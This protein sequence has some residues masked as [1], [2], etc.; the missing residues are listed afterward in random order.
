MHY[1]AS[2]VSG[3]ISLESFAVIQDSNGLSRPYSKGKF[4]F[5]GSQKLF[6]KGVTYGAF[7]PDAQRREYWNTD[8]IERD[9]AAMSDN[10]FNAVRIP[11]TVPPSELLDIAHRYGLWVMVGL[12]AEQYVGYLMQHRQDTPDIGK[13]IRDRVRSVAGHPALLAYALGNE[14]S[15]HHARWIRPRRI[16]RY[17]ER[18]YRIVKEEDPQGLV[19]YVNYPTTEY[20]RLPFLDFVCFNVYLESKEALEHYLPRLQNIAGDRPL[21]MSEVGIDSLR[22]GELKQAQ[23][24]N[25]QI[26]T[27]FTMGCVGAFVFSWTDEWFRGG[28]YVHDWAFGLTTEDREPKLALPTVREAFACGFHP[29]SMNWPRISVVVCTYNGGRTLADCLDGCQCLD[30]PNYEVIIV[31]DGSTDNSAEIAERLGFKLIT[32]ENRGLSHAR[33]VGMIHATGEIVAY[34]DD[35]ARPDPH[36]LTYLALAFTRTNHAA[37]GGPNIAPAGDGEIADCV[38]NAPGGPMHVLISDTEA[39]HIPGCNMAIRRKIL[40]EIGGFDEQ[41]RVAGDDVDICWRLKDSGYTIGYC[42][43]AMVWHHRRNSVRAFWKQQRGYGRAE[44]LLEQKWPEKY[45]TAGHVSWGGRVYGPGAMYL[46]TSPPRIYHG[47]WGSAPFQMA[48]PSHPPLFIALSAT[49]EWW[50]AVMLLAAISCLSIFWKPLLIFLPVL[51]TALALPMI[52]AWL[53]ALNARFPT[54]TRGRFHDWQLRLVTASLHLAQPLARLYGRIQHGL[55]LWRWRGPREWCFPVPC[56]TAV[57][58]RTWIEHHRRLELIEESCSLLSTTT[59]R[60]GPFDSWDIEVRGG[61]LGCV[62]LLMAIEDQGSGTQFVQ[63]KCQPVFYYAGIAAA[64]LFGGLALLAAQDG[65]WNAAL[66]LGGLTLAAGVRM[67]VDCGR[68]AAVARMA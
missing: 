9:F 59:R 29:A 61:M 1:G 63:V 23:V 25:W 58:T 11:H 24:L 56:Q 67:L 66:V 32:T 64:S 15:S 18:L 31:N 60:G 52:Q 38:A 48:H 62:R 19:T 41:F 27:S 57:F 17:L 30:Y 21:V 40:K 36:W 51:G 49:P 53:G 47:V 3:A 5:S 54:R 65:A 12:S 20:L 2:A 14:V 4:L 37:I 7:E 34:T 33:N 6:I 13:I 26:R 43:A 42:A 28:D 16:E 55:T 46:L 35:D 45:N 68:S 10:G 50:L 8:R 44:A 39:E 22:H